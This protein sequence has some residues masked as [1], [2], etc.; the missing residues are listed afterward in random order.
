MDILKFA[1]TYWT[2]LVVTTG[3]GLVV[4]LVK[5]SMKIVIDKVMDEI[6]E[7]FKEDVEEQRAIKYGVLSLSHYILY[8]QCQDL[9]R[10]GYIT[11]SELDDLEHLY[12]GY[13]AL[14][15]NGTGTKL[16]KDCKNLPIKS[17]YDLEKELMK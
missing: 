4:Y 17:Q 13:S 5:H 1:T 16:F 3:T 15:G 7:H 9:I 14:G 11:I 10:R 8:K 12:S 2:Q 6:D